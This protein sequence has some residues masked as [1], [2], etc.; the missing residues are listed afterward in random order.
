[1]YISTIS[2]RFDAINRSQRSGKSHRS[3][4]TGGRQHDHDLDDANDL[5]RA[6]D[7]NDRTDSRSAQMFTGQSKLS[8]RRVSTRR[9]RFMPDD[10][11]KKATTATSATVVKPGTEDILS[12]FVYTGGESGR[13]ESDGGGL[14]SAHD[15]EDIISQSS[16][17][18]AIS[19]AEDEMAYFA[20]RPGQSDFKVRRR[21]TLHP[22]GRFRAGWDIFQILLMTCKSSLLIG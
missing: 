21:Y 12:G 10:Q 13:N 18:Q 9:L 22:H 2:T 4:K 7:S 11:M 15:E 8:V 1:V 17:R 14:E 19:D 6:F 20:N 16:M 5:A 3:S